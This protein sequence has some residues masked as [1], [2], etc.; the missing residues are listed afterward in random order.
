MAGRCCCAPQIDSAKNQVISA[1]NATQL[2]QAGIGNSTI[3]IPVELIARRVADLLY[4]PVDRSFEDTVLVDLTA[5]KNALI[6]LKSRDTNLDKINQIIR[7]TND[8]FDLQVDSQRKLTDSISTLATRQQAKEL[9]FAIT[10]RASA[11]IKRVND[12]EFW[13]NVKFL[14]VLAAIAAVSA[15]V[16]AQNK[17]VLAAI[18]ASLARILSAIAAIKFPISQKDIEDAVRRVRDE[19]KRNALTLETKQVSVPVCELNASGEPVLGTTAI[20]YGAL[21]NS[22]NLSQSPLFDAMVQVLS[23]IR[24]EGVLKC[25]SGDNLIQ[26]VILTATGVGTPN[27]V[28]FAY[29]QTLDAKYF[30]LEVTQWDGNLVRT[31]K[32][33]GLE[34]EFGGGNWSLI[35]GQFSASLPFVPIFNRGNRLD[36]PGEPGGWGVRVSPKQ[37]VEFIVLAVGTPIL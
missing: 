21:K 11:V 30:V 8:I 10:D 7:N 19:I 26:E 28:L 16:F 23:G 31:Y 14:A 9:L 15:L 18:G 25:G 3:N 17:L 13:L 12:L 2:K 4:K 34:S 29:P 6:Q 32:L 5:I 35:Q 20:S 24:T 36:V 22:S 27:D 37:G 33:A 1:L